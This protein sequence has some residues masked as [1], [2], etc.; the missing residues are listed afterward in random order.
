MGAGR[1]GQL[2]QFL[3]SIFMMIG[4][5]LESFQGNRTAAAKSL[6]VSVRWVQLKLKELGLQ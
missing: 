2:M 4:K 1:C 5:R 3:L 6:G